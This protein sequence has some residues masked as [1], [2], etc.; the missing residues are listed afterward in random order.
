MAN[1]HPADAAY[2]V[3]S[4]A[5]GAKSTARYHRQKS[6][7]SCRLRPPTRLTALSLRNDS[8]WSERS[9]AVPRARG[10][11]FINIFLTRVRTVI[12]KNDYSKKWPFTLILMNLKFQK[13]TL[14]SRHYLESFPYLFFVANYVK[15]LPY[16][17]LIAFYNLGGNK[18]K[19]GA[20]RKH[21]EQVKSISSCSD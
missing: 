9:I 1:S 8:L 17:N 7:T 14:I 11:S 6:G 3:C 18:R 4:R 21:N 10:Y 15:K 16:L 19:F 2:C 12:K 13:R 5:R 20:R